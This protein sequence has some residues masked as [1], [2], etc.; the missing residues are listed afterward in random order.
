MQDGDRM[1]YLENCS[2]DTEAAF[3]TDPESM[4][5]ARI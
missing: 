5:E 4:K 3:L 2:N 1:D